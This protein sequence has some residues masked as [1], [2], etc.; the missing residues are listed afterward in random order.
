VRAMNATYEMQFGVVERPTHYNTRHDFAKY[1][2]PGHRFAD[3][4]EHGFGLALLSDC[5]YGYSTLHGTLRL[6]LL[7]APTSPDPKADIGRHRFAYALYPHQGN[8]QAAEV[9]AEARRFSVPLVWTRGK[10]EPV[11]FFSSDDPNLVLDTV[12]KSEEGYAVI[13]RLYEAHGARGRARIKSSLPFAR[14]SV[15]DLLEREVSPVPVAQ[16]M[17]EVSY[18]PFQILTIKLE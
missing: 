1:E 17:L 2:V 16:G 6:S 4:S 15:C 10:A 11:S 18:R 9:V 12:K 3:L 8:W 14:A 13:L 5:K 7:R